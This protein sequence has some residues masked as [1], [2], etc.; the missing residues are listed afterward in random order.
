MESA[1]PNNALLNALPQYVLLDE[2]LAVYQS[3]LRAVREGIGNRKKWVMLVRGGPGTGKAA[4]AV[5][6]CYV[7]FMDNDTEDFVRS[8]VEEMQ[9]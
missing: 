7:Y 3:V 1:V 6:G 9:L 4:V 8:R 5:K 2:Q